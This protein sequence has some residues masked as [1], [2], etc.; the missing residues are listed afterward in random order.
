MHCLP[1]HSRCLETCK[2]NPHCACYHLRDGHRCREA[3]SQW[4]KDE[5]EIG[6]I[7]SLDKTTKK[8]K[9]LLEYPWSEHSSQ[10]IERLIVNRK[11]GE[12][13]FFSAD[14]RTGITINEDQDDYLINEYWTKIDVNTTEQ[15]IT[16]TKLDPQTHTVSHFR[17]DDFLNSYPVSSVECQPYP[18]MDQ[19]CTVRFTNVLVQR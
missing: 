17:A 15:H 8:K 12:R 9:N 2:N 5:L 13:L 6:E 18:M 7:Q 1:G 4:I 3:T 14:R 11:V 19:L 16:Y 10:Q